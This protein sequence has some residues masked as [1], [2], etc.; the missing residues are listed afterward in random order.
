MNSFQGMCATMALGLLVLVMVIGVSATLPSQVI[1]CTSGSNNC[2]VTNSYGTFSDRTTCRVAAAVYPS[3][4]MELLHAVSN[5]SMKKQKMKVVTVYS[6]GMTKISCPGGPSGTGLAISTERL[7][8]VASIDSASM[9][10]TVESGITMSRIVDAAAQVGLAVSHS[11]YWLGLTL[12]GVLSTGGH[13]SSLFG[14][15]SAVH[16]YVVGMRLVVPNPEPINGYYARIVD[17][18]ED[19]PDLLAAKVS[20]G[21]LGVISQVTLQL[22]P[23]FKRS[24]TNRVSL[25]ADFE[26]T[27]ATFGETTEYGDITW[28]PSQAKVVYRDD[29]R[30]HTSIAGDGNNDLFPLQLSLLVESTRAV[31]ETFEATGNSKGKCLLSKIQVTAALQGG[32]ALKN[33]GNLL[34]FTGYPVIGNQSKMQGSESCMKGTDDELLTACQWDPQIKGRFFHQ[35][36]FSIPLANV[37]SFFVD[38]KKLRDMDPT[39]LCGAELY[40]GF[41]TR[42]VRESTA[43]LGKTTDSFQID[44]TYYRS[45][46]PN[47]PRLHEDVFEEIEQMAFFK[48]NGLPHWGKNRNVGFHGVRDKLGPKGDMFIQVM[49]RYDPDGLFS[50]EWTDGILGLRGAGVL[51]EKNGCALEGLCICS[52]HEHCAPH[53]GYYCRQGHVFTEARVCRKIDISQANRMDDACWDHADDLSRVWDI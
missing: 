36:A 5:A 24:I 40:G 29:F 2:T 52:M 23:M 30:V 49:E 4:E 26:N 16:E 7:N 20:L 47:E 44:M 6:H 17:L 1:N 46:D 27:I 25:D 32:G 41:L 37:T 13:G 38:V 11:P 18:G 33:G 21:V 51:I 48:Y 22:E 28:Y 31:E 19:D 42:F 43:Y 3:D 35:T 53:K 9:R 12:G 39:A 8:H 15:G 45:R 14:K 10:I 50:S 34:G